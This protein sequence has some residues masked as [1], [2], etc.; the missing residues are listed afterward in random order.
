MNRRKEEGELR[1]LFIG[2]AGFLMLGMTARQKM[3][4]PID[5]SSVRTIVYPAAGYDIEAVAEIVRTFIYT[6][7]IY[8]IDPN[9]NTQSFTL[10]KFPIPTFLCM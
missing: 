4:E 10:E 1:S 2:F 3:D 8:L 5:R 9:Y 6:D 7:T